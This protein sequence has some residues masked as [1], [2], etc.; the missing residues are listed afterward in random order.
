[1]PVAIELQNL[2]DA[3]L[4]RE[5]SASIEHALGDKHGE[6]RVSIA[7]SRASENWEM[8][9]EGLNGFERRYTL[10]GA[11]GE[12]QPVRFDSDMHLLLVTLEPTTTIHPQRQGFLDL[13]QTEDRPI[14]F[15][16]RGLTSLGS[17]YLNVVDTRDA[18]YARQDLTAMQ[19]QIDPLPACCA[20]LGC[21]MFLEQ[22]SQ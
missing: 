9:V 18:F 12:H 6:W 3:E 21:E 16:R 22:F 5:I 13:L 14:K 17:G 4:C 8:R 15:P 20:N 2:G 1:M 7:G 11:A 19:F 10:A